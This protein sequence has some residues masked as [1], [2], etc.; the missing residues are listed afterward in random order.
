MGRG[1]NGPITTLNEAL[2]TLNEAVTTLVTTLITTHK[3]ENSVLDMSWW[4]RVT[5]I[6]SSAATTRREADAC[7]FRAC[8][9]DI[10]TDN[11]K[12]RLTQI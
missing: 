8:D 7:R 2:T 11:I 5:P 1:D 6:S 3:L 9:V 4:R 10:A 12:T